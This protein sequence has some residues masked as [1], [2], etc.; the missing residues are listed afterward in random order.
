[1]ILGAFLAA[2]AAAIMAAMPARPMAPASSPT[3]PAATATSPGNGNRAAAGDAVT[4]TILHVND[5]HGHTEPYML[6]GKS[7]GGYSR[8]STLVANFRESRDANLILLLHA[9][10]EFSRG[11]LLTT[12]TL[13]AANI[14]L[15]NFLHLDAWTPGNGE[16]YIGID[17]L[18]KRLAEA[19]FPSLTAN[20]TVKGDGNCF[21]R[22]YVIK[23]VGPVKVAI[24]GLC[25]VYE[26]DQK[27]CGLLAADPDE[28]AARIVP[29]LRKQAD[30][31]IALTH[32]G[33]I[34]DLKLAQK[35]EGIDVIIGG[36]SHTKLEEGK[37]V[38]GPGDKEVIVCQ[39]GEYMQHLGCLELK[40]QFGAGGWHI[41]SAQ[42]RLIAIDAST[43]EDP[44]V[45]ALIARMSEATS[46]PATRPVLV[47]AER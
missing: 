6:S 3:S 37:R 21:E 47:P 18:R 15:L 9:G 25:T 12:R 16:Y 31:V 27:A 11:D 38:A 10:D 44:A 33:Y 26:N 14:R 36:H 35:V 19:N 1:M 46:R 29:D 41:A 23:R 4:L 30:I 45:K 43:P 22:P 8:L 28:T 39:A 7:V 5:I 42:A 13:G 24:F 17:A 34:E 2:A 20:V 40:M 32:L